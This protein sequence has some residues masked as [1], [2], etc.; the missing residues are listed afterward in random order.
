MGIP[1]KKRVFK[2]IINGNFPILWKDL[3]PQIQ[4][5]NRTPNYLNV[6]GPPSRYI[7]LK[8]SEVNDKERILKVVKR[9]NTIRETSLDYHRIIS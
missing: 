4:E 3:D 2:Q 7:I 5:A 1:E 9:K 8:M 6:K